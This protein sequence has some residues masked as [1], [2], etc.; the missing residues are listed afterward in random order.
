M[1]LSSKTFQEELLQRLGRL[2]E[3]MHESMGLRVKEY[4]SVLD[5]NRLLHGELDSLRQKVS[6]T[7]CWICS[8]I[9]VYC[10]RQRSKFAGDVM[11]MGEARRDDRE[12]P[13]STTQ[14]NHYARLERTRASHTRRAALRRACKERSRRSENTRAGEKSGEGVGGESG[15]ADDRYRATS[16]CEDVRGE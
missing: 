16:C 9:C 13:N 1:E 14:H 6:L 11:L 12:V 2:D 3:S 10:A 15:L 8:S 5:R 7:T 4:E